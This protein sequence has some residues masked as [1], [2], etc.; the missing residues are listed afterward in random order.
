MHIILLPKG[1]PMWFI[2]FLFDLEGKECI[3]MVVGF[4]VDF[5][6]NG[7]HISRGSAL[8]IFLDVGGPDL[9]SLKGVTLGC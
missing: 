4:R 2:P 3:G 8:Y 9:L 1:L 7:H 5:G 6:G